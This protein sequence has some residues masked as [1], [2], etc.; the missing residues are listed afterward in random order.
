MTPIQLIMRV[1][2]TKTE[3]PCDMSQNTPGLWHRLRRP[4]FALILG[5]LPFWL[6]MG[7]TQQASVNGMVV[8]DTRFNILGLILAIAGLV[9]AA[10]MLKNDGSYGEPARGWPRTVLCVAAGLLCIFQIGQSAGLYNVN[11]GQSIDNLQSR[12]FGPSEPRPK[13]LASELDQDVRARTEQRSATVSQVL[14]RDDI[15]TSL[16]RIHANATLYNLY[17]EKC[18]NPGKRFVLD[19][20]PALLTDKDKTYVEK[21]QQLAA[22]NASDRFDCQG[23]PMR[24][25]MSNWLAGDVLRD[26]AN[27]AVQT[28]AYRERFGDK[29]AGAGDDTLVTTGLGVW[30]GD[31]ISQV[32]TAFG[33]TAMP[34]PA[35]KS[36]KTKL[37]FPDRGM[38][39][40][41]DFAGK[42]DTITVRAPFTGSIVGLKI[43]DSRRTV[44][45]LLGESWIDVRLPYDN[46]AADYDI[47]FRKKTPGTQS[48][49]IDRRQGNPQ[50]VLLL[51]G[52][53]YASQIDE[54]KLVTPRP[55]G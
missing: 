47:Q 28:A 15:A 54:I 24:D 43:G 10:K 50:T 7:T 6:F 38:E 35:G 31:S 45:R 52:A 9:M 13:S 18:N 49:W 26:R 23:E 5:M 17:A 51:Q 21:A 8:Q 16:A 14:L 37:D 33:T 11:V 3:R 22:R 40:V 4:I 48:Q 53:S 27:L 39:L 34:V 55:P 32:Q 44:N 42:V 36:G 1:L 30:L 46:A 41:F 12:L 19:E 20:I 25:F 2:E 29:P